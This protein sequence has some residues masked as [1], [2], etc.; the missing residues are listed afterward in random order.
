MA[1]S[2]VNTRALKDEVTGLL[3]KGKF[4]RAADVLEQLARAEPKEMTHRLKLGDTYRRLDQK[5][6]A[7]AA[8]QYAARFFGDEGQLIK[9]IGAVKIILEL[10][11][12]N[13]AAQAQLAEMNNRRLG[14][15]T[16]ESAGLRPQSTPARNPT[17]LGDAAAAAHAIGTANQVELE[18]GDDDEPLELD[19]GKPS[20]GVA[21][22]RGPVLGKNK[23]EARAPGPPPKIRPAFDLGNNEPPDLRVPPPIAPPRSGKR[24][25]DPIELPPEEPQSAAQ[26]IDL[27]P[28]EIGSAALPMPEAPIELDPSVL[29]PLDETEAPTAK[30]PVP[31]AR[32]AT[33][34]PS[35]PLAKIAVAPRGKTKPSITVS[36]EIDFEDDE[37]QTVARPIAD[38][39][40]GSDEVEV[41]ALAADEEVRNAAKNQPAAQRVAT[42]K[43]PLFDDLSQAAFVELVNKLDFHR[44]EPGELII[45]EGDPGRSFYVIAAGQV[46]IYKTADDGAEMTLARLGEG[47]FF[48]E[49]ALLSGAPRTANVVAEEDTEL[50]EVT[51]VVL[52]ELAGKYPQVVTSLKNFYRQR[53]LANVM[54]I[55]PLFRD[56][57]PQERKGI[58]EKFRMKQ[59][60]ADEVMIEEGKS[61]DGLYVV[62][63]GAVQ[64]TATKDDKPVELARLKEGEI[65]GEMSLLTRKPATATVTAAGNAILLRLPRES[66]QELVLTHPQIL[67]L[68]SELTEKRKSATEAILSEENGGMA[69]V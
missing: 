44:H 63:H 40:S 17:E 1:S 14:K 66:F 27:D 36:D 24:S 64:V 4:D 39:L 49:M 58:A 56:F 5:V 31:A 34:T 11:P 18:P 2:T 3:R 12:G 20:R 21:P 47:A 69:F 53:L 65:F 62:L 19:D 13:G 23:P 7:I 37:P 16:M 43:V 57:D 61:S 6:K 38:L 52:R 50:L 59:A 30:I 8:Y 51:D 42:K 45:R 25:H 41:L 10:D 35:Q 48:G 55:S 28:D 29:V 9:A 26:K 22:A 54:A 60:A 67:E 46:R 15:V 32:Q 68:V 33:N